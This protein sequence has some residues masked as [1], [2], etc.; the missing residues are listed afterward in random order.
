M[1]DSIFV[2]VA[3]YC[4]PLLGFTLDSL[5]SQAADPSRV[6][7]GVV[8]QAPAGQGLR[9]DDGWS[10]QHLRWTRVDAL[11]ARGPCWA[12]ALAMALYQGETWFL[13]VDSHT[14]FEPGWDERLIAWG[15]AALAH[16]PR[17]LLTCYPNPFTLH[18]GQPRAQLVGAEVLAF[19]VSAHSSFADT[20]PV[21]MFECVPVA[22]RTAVAGLHLAGGCLFAP[23]RIVEELPY[24]PQLYFHGEE[25]AY[26]LR[27]WTRGWDLLHIPGMPMY[28]LYTPPGAAPRP[29]HWSPEHDQQRAVRSAALELSAR[30]RLAA[31]LWQGA[32]L[33]VY[34]LGTAR[35]LADYAAFSGIDYG[36]RRI[37]PHARKARFG[38]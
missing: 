32:D 14:W 38:Y 31:L 17:S 20:H 30:Q 11:L 3:A 16:N 29:L 12:R 8:E 19:V 21:L 18:E 37:E 5:R 34:G 1:K 15:R 23:G 24:D 22:S 35:T 28:H 2:S 4:D 25:Q 27:A 33:G 36:A 6:F 10:R 7:A 13:Q 9:R 26:A